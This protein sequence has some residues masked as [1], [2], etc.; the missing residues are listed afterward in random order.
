MPQYKCV[1]APKD[2]VIE[3][4]GDMGGA[5]S[6]FSSLINAETEG[7]WVFQSLEEIMVTQK[8]GCIAAIFGGRATQISYNMLIFRK[9]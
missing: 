4:D 9:D 6:S 8:P 5:V 1:P 3:S 2:I 7:G